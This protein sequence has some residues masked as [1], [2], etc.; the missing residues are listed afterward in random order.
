MKRF[1]VLLFAL[2]AIPAISSAKGAVYVV[3]LTGGVDAGLPAY[4]RRAF[5]EAREHHA[6]AV[7]IHINTFGG[8]VDVA[9]ELKDI[10]LNAQLPTIAFVDRRAISAGALIALSASKVAMS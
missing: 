10:I 5:D 8:R 7:V 1:F 3:E 9:T 4:V 6:S 2:L